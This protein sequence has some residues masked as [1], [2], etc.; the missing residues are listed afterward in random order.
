[1]A[2]QLG[3]ARGTRE[4]PPEQPQ[5]SRR[6]VWERR[7]SWGWRFAGISSDLGAGGFRQG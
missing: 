3:E 6:E 4:E 2:S 5:G 1:M 7:G